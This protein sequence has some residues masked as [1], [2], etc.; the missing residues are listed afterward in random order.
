MGAISSNGTANMSCRTNASRSAGV[1]VSS[2]TSNARPTE[3]ACAASCAGSTT[4]C[5]QRTVRAR[6]VPRESSR[7]ALRE[8]SMS[9]HTRA[10]DRRQPAA[11]VLDGAGVGAAQP[12]PG[13]LHGVVRLGAGTEHPVRHPLQ[14]APVRLEL[15]GQ[16]TVIVH[17]SHIL[18]GSRHTS[19]G[20]EPA[21]VTAA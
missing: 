21:D 11:E 18:V 4:S 8:R 15:L 9:R 1:S 17:S 16:P 3:S 6:D 20:R 5:E 2:T 14:M 10:D 7:R 12:D 19:D 13:F